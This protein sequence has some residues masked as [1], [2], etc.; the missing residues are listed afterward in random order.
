VTQLPP[1]G[2]FDS[3]GRPHG[4]RVMHECG[5][6]SERLISRD[7]PQCGAGRVQLPRIVL[8]RPMFTTAG[9]LL[10]RYRSSRLSPM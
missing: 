9:P 5:Q 7:L 4:A 3:E 10:R 6:P 8:W 2:V 1:R